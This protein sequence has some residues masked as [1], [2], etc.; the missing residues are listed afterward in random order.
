MA[1]P[2]VSLAP[3]LVPGAQ[4]RELG[5]AISYVFKSLF[6]RTEDAFKRVHLMKRDS[7]G[8]FMPFNIY[9][10]N[11]E[12]FT[13]SLNNS[14][15]EDNDGNIYYDEPADMVAGKCAGLLAGVP[16]Y[17]LGKIGWH[18]CKTPLQVV[19]VVL[20]TL[21]GMGQK[22]AA[23]ELYGA[24]RELGNGCSQAVRET[25]EEIFEVVKAPLFGLGMEF[26]AVYGLVKPFHAR[27]AVQKIE[28][29]WY[30]GVSY[31]QDIRHDYDHSLMAFFAGIRDGKPWYLAYCFQIRGNTHNPKYHII[32]RE[33]V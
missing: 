1:T 9:N 19:K 27:Y 28:H 24:V 26:A 15:I 32:R 23:M 20:N 21:V 13:T 31:K 29:A 17:T 6:E 3:S 12:T 8:Q 4:L 30:C 7:H 2:T 10:P 5:T 25:A 14:Y 22:L 18:V 33:P 16:L 11:T